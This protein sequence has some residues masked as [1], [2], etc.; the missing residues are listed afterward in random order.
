M[1]ECETKL[2]RWGNSIGFV[3]PKREAQRENLRADQKVKAIIT[4]KEPLRVKDIFGQLS[5]KKPTKQL[6]AEVD[7]ELDSKFMK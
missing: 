1:I 6:M 4:R 3:I 7:K 5:L 2:K